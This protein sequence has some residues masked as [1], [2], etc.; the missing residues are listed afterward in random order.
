MVLDAVERKLSPMNDGFHVR[1]Q[2]I[3]KGICAPVPKQPFLS[4]HN[5]IIF[6]DLTRELRQFN[7]LISRKKATDEIRD[8]DLVFFND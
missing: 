3:V 8:N 5:V 6:E 2:E 1:N 4:E 7:K